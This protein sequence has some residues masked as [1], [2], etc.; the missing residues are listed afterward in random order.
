MK[1]LIEQ[2]VLSVNSLPSIREEREDYAQWRGHFGIM[3]IGITKEKIRMLET[4]ISNA[5]EA[6]AEYSAKEKEMFNL[7]KA[8]NHLDNEF[9]L[10]EVAYCAH[11]NAVQ[12]ELADT[13][14][15]L[16]KLK[17]KLKKLQA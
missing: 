10:A 17:R 3:E 6:V 1:N 13:V 8:S 14:K 12:E 15:E 9:Y 2:A 11:K 4:I 5:R 7:W 16:Q